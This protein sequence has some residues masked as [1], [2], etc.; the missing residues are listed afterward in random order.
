MAMRENSKNTKVSISKTI[1]KDLGIDSKK[2]KKDDLVCDILTNSTKS[3][4]LSPIVRDFL[5]L[6]LH[7]HRSKKSVTF[8]QGFLSAVGSIK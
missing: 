8:Q 6:T 1:T 4:T 3:D 5:S 7:L 2:K